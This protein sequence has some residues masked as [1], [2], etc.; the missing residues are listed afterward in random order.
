MS[1]VILLEAALL[2]VLTQ[3][4]TWAGLEAGA[5]CNLWK[6]TLQIMLPLE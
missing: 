1:V 3:E 2:L 6:H 4:G 5:L